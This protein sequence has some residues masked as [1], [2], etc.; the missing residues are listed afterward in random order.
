M[1]YRYEI[2]QE[3]TWRDRRLCW[4]YDLEGTKEEGFHCAAWF[5]RREDAELWKLE[6]EE[7][8]RRG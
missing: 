7:D 5:K 8:Q 2:K 3:I 4:W 6:K 1:K